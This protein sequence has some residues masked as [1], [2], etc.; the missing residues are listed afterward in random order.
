VVA[1]KVVAL[2]LNE[3]EKWLFS[4]W[5][6]FSAVVF[7]LSLDVTQGYFDMAS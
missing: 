5:H 2:D 7:S 4:P 6:R 1:V 3:D